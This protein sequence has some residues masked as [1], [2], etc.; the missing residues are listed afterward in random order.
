MRIKNR[1]PGPINRTVVTRSTSQPVSRNLGARSTDTP[2]PTYQGRKSR[3]PG[4][5][6]GQ[7][8]WRTVSPNYHTMVTIDAR[9]SA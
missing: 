8:M 4:S 3:R 6:K 7:G 5:D 2:V 9:W 1:Q